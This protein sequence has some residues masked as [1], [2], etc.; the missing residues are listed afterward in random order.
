MMPRYLT[1]SRLCL[2][3]LV[4]I[5]LSGRTASTS[6]L[7]LLSFIASHI[8]APT[9]DDERPE[10]GISEI[11]TGD[12]SVFAN[13]LSQWDSVIPGRTVYDVFLQR[14]WTLTGLDSL[15]VLF[16]HLG[17][18]TAPVVTT[19][20]DGSRTLSR[21]S[22]LGQFIR[23]C[24]VEFTRL[25]F[26]DSQALW[27]AFEVYISP[28][29]GTWAQKHPEASNQFAANRS[30]P[31]SF[32]TRYEANENQPLTTQCISTEE[33]DN[34]VTFSLRQMQRLGSRV[35]PGIKVKLEQ[36]ITDQADSSMQSQQ[37]FLAFFEYWRA[38]QYTMALESI[39]RYFDYSLVSKTGN[40]NMRVYYQYA[41]LHLSV[42]HADF[43]C[44]EES[45]DAM[46]ECI[47]TARE[48]QDAVCLNFALSWLLYLRQVHPGNISSFGISGGLVGGGGGEQDEIALLK[49]KA[50]ETKHW[51][52]M[53][54]T[55]L[56]E[57][58]LEMNHN[59][60]TSKGFEHIV[61]ASFLNVQHD[62]RDL[63]S[64]AAL[65]YG[66]SFQRL[67]YDHLCSRIYESI[68][69]VHRTHCPLSDLVRATCRLSYGQAQTGNYVASKTTLDGM[70]V[71]A[72]GVLR[73]EQRLIGFG[74]LAQLRRSLRH[75][76]LRASSVYLAE[77]RIL[78][79]FADPEICL[80]IDLI[81]IDF[82]IQSKELE[83][84]LKLVNAHLGR[85]K[86]A[87]G[88]DIAQRLHFLVSKAKIFSDAGRPAKGFSIA[89]RAAS[90][91]S[92]NW[93]VFIL[94]E[95]CAVLGNILNSLSEFE[96]ARDLV[97]AIVPLAIEARKV[98]LIAQL[99]VILAESNVGL[100]GH[101]TSLSA[102]EKMGMMC[103]AENHL[104]RSREAYSTLE[105]FQ[106]VQECLVMKAQIVRWRGDE[107]A[108]AEIDDLYA[109]LLTEREK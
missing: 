68:Q 52:L 74:I 19:A 55:L 23:R 95:S 35:P 57:S 99:F 75:D 42:L 21:S 78:R 20:G 109:Q 54:S 50:K 4:D 56:E 16:E 1:P 8:H 80:E 83:K 70:A 101:D 47:A 41:L 43:D 33:T 26:A 34:L 98:G 44:W 61:Q 64:G 53:S 92:K 48:N 66:S 39:H 108:V 102:T 32:D 18:L 6:R 17:E 96:A 90:I 79:G 10:N 103:T 51:S 73:L 45:I 86:N 91:A 104:D 22:P 67:G 65:F 94:I 76:D 27:D 63:M 11:S 12:A 15:Y 85:L 58:K 107:A 69:H 49:A 29:F 60:T 81:E 100:V 71:Q 14:L 46:D 89:M 28:T 105:D 97:S 106:G 62:L 40:D 59:G 5:Y 13:R 93:L 88:S 2:L 31:S 36:W 38:G 77:L 82:H 3:A 9:V 37:H 7:E 24:G 84:A 72:K 30:L 25:Q 87:S